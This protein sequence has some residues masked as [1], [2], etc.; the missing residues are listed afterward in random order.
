LETTEAERG[1]TKR[2]IQGLGGETKDRNGDRLD[3]TG[4]RYDILEGEEKTCLKGRGRNRIGVGKKRRWG[5]RFHPALEERVDE[6]YRDAKGLPRKSPNEGERLSPVK[7]SKRK[8][9]SLEIAEK[10]GLS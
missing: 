8:N 2:V 1:H 9:V 6:S 10:G 7:V 3:D 4:Q 5:G